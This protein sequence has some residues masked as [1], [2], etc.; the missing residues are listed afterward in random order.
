[1]PRSISV[2]VQIA[3]STVLLS[4]TEQLDTIKLIDKQ[5]NRESADQIPP[6]R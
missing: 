1:M 3:V 5:M 2:S 6:V 4:I